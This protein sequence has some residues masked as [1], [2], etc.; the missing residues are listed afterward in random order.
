[1]SLF[2]Y[3][4]VHREDAAIFNGAMTSSSAGLSGIL[5]AAYDFAQFERIADVGGGHGALLYAIIS[6]NPR[7]HGVLADMPW[8]VAGAVSLREPAIAGRCEIVATDFFHSVPDGADGYVMKD[9]IH[10][11]ED[12]DALKILKNANAPSDLMGD[13]C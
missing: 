2:E 5:V 10:D 3:L 9:I 7:L 13:S 8:V 4:A 11:W 1:M 6:A 12:V